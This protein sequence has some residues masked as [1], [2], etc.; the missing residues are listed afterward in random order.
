MYAH[1]FMADVT[2][3]PAQAAVPRVNP[4][5]GNP[6]QTAAVNGGHYSA[7]ADAIGVGLQYAF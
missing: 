5:K 6:T 4:V 1:V 2:V 3:S 7:G